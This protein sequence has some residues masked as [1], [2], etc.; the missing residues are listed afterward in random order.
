MKVKGCH[1]IWYDSV[2]KTLFV[3]YGESRNMDTR[4]DVY[5]DSQISKHWVDTSLSI[6]YSSRVFFILGK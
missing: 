1:P 2:H 3:E 6:L 5:F 4:G